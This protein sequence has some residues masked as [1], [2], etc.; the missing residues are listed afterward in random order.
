[1]KGALRP[2]YQF[3]DL[4]SPH[5]AAELLASYDRRTNDHDLSACDRWRN[6]IRNHTEKGMLCIDGDR[7]RIEKLV[8]WAKGQRVAGAPDWKSRLAG[9][10]EVG[11]TMSFS[12]SLPALSLEAHMI[13][14]PTT[15]DASHAEIR[16][17]SSQCLELAREVE[18]LKKE[19]AALRPAAEKYKNWAEKN[20][21]NGGRRTT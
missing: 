4:L 2:T 1:M 10:P 15:L 8:T 16:K 14:L 13:S 19:N 21:I 3:G 20:R 12:G 6:R 7:Y 18:Y 5:Q 9:L 17:L 11:G